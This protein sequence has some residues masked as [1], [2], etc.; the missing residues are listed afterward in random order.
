MAAYVSGSIFGAVFLSVVA[1]T[2]ALVRH[3]LPQEQWP[4][5]VSTF[6]IIFAVGQIIG[7]GVVGVLADGPGGLRAGL[8]LSACALLIGAALARAQRAVIPS[9]S[10]RQ[11]L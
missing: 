9:E 1:A 7:P 3:N 10:Q 8:G 5:G 11:T 4:A 6:T 2:T